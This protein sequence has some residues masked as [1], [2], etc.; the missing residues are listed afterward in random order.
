MTV[1]YPDFPYIGF[2]HMPHK[3]AP[4]VC[5]EP[6]SSL[7]SRSGIIEDLSQ[8]A[9]LLHADPGCAWETTW[10]VTVR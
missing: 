2:W 8:Q 9:D 10:C 5:V 1:D 7:P 4:Y 3:E 6:W